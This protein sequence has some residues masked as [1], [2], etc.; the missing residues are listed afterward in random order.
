MNIYHRKKQWKLALLVF[1]ITIGISSLFVTN[2]LVKELKEEERRKIELWAQATSQVANSY[3]GNN[4]NFP[5]R[6][7]KG[8][9]T[10]PV[11][12]VD[13][14]DSIKEWRNITNLNRIDSLLIR[15][16]LKTLPVITPSFLRKELREKCVY[17]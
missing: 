2:Q 13:E 3:D 4:V 5:L 16:K 11:I 17:I 15:F 10:I 9:K 1:A 8:N 6:V 14:C 12:L 7:I